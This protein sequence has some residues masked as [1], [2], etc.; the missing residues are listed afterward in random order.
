MKKVLSTGRNILKKDHPKKW[1]GNC[2]VCGTQ[3]HC[4]AEDLYVHQQW[5]VSDCPTCETR[6]GVNIV[7]YR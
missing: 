5:E 1:S 4:E 6:V 7:A 3:F 2:S